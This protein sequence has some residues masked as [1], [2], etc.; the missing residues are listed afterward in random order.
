MQRN[1]WISLLI[2]FFVFVPF[3]FAKKGQYKGEG[4]STLS[5]TTLPLLLLQIDTVITEYYD[6]TK[7]DPDVEFADTFFVKATND[8]FHFEMRNRFPLILID[9]LD[10]TFNISDYNTYSQIDRVGEKSAVS[11]KVKSL[12]E[13]Y[14][15]S[16]VMIPT[17]VYM[18]HITTKPTAWRDSPSYEHPVNYKAI[19]KVYIQIW[20]NKGELL[21]ENR[22]FND[23]GRPILYKLVNRKKKKRDGEVDIAVYAKRYYS[24]PIVKSLNKAIKK[25]MQF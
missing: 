6:D 4:Y 24:P 5:D 14:K 16:F 20:N 17:L 7:I 10:T 1:I 18:K 23:T 15:A 9:S 3:S 22:G 2:V 21:L 12:A 13:K 19:S 25:A 8:L 11:E